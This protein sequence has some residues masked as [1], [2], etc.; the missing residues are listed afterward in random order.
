[1]L[2][3]DVEIDLGTI[4]GRRADEMERHPR[5]FAAHDDIESAP[6]GHDDHVGRA[7]DERAVDGGEIERLLRP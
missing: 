6:H 3:A 2:H 1:M 4:G 5:R 7:D